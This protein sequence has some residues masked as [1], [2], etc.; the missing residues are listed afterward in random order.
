MKISEKSFCGIFAAKFDV[1]DRT[2]NHH[3]LEIRISKLATTKEQLATTYH[4]SPPLAGKWSQVVGDMTG[5][6]PHAE[7]AR[8]VVERYISQNHQLIYELPALANTQCDHSPP[9][10][11]TR[12]GKRWKVVTVPVS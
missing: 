7:H 10:A 1:K 11:T 2:R 3:D 12:H 6:E 8:Q 9:L 4:H 5:T